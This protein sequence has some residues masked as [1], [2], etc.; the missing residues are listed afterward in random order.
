MIKNTPDD[1]L[2]GNAYFYLGEIAMR[3]QKPTAA[4]KNYDHLIEHF[5]RQ[6]E[7]IRQR[8]CTKAKR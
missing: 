6:P 2:S 7:G 1:N 5:P 8:T 4:I 3:T